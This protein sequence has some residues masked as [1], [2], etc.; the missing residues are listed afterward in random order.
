MP[1]RHALC[2]WCQAVNTKENGMPSGNW[3][4]AMRF[5]YFVWHPVDAQR[6]CGWSVLVIIRHEVIAQPI[7]DKTNRAD[8]QRE[9]YDL[10]NRHD[11][12]L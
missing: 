3:G 4:H 9:G 7:K 11:A 2:A 12:S 10:R 1:R 5:D 8:P 6:R